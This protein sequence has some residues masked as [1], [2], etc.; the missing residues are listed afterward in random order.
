M[1]DEAALAN[2]EANDFFGRECWVCSIN[3]YSHPMMGADVELGGFIWGNVAFFTRGIMI[4]PLGKQRKM[5]ETLY[6]AVYSTEL[7]YF[8]K[9]F[10]P[11]IEMGRNGISPIVAKAVI[12]IFLYL[13]KKLS[14]NF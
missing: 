8:Q 3:N 12:L 6:R 7:E 11:N 9:A 13:K 14:L 2:S 4:L 10:K 1:E 5:K